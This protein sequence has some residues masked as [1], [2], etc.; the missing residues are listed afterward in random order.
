MTT[1]APRLSPMALRGGTAQWLA[2]LESLTVEY[3]NGNT[4]FFGL[5]AAVGGLLLLAAGLAQ[6]AGRHFL[7]ALLALSAAPAIVLTSIFTRRHYQ[8]Q[9]AVAP[10]DPRT[11]GGQRLSR[12]GLAV[13]EWGL[14]GLWT[15]SELYSCGVALSDVGP[16][17]LLTTRLASF[18]A[19]ASALATGALLLWRRPSRWDSS[20]FLVVLIGQQASSGF[21][22]VLGPSLPPIEAVGR[23]ALEVARPGAGAVWTSF[24]YGSLLLVLGLGSHWMHRRT[25][26]R[27]DALR[28]TAAASASPE[29]DP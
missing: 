22:R 10:A 7:A 12:R 14:L 11:R 8:R 15:L 3:A 20:W 18:L 13:V 21:D 25:E 2:D 28:A 23:Q 27:L 29:V 24:I 6:I 17:A 4:V 26:A 16:D 9:G 19:L 5:S 1:P